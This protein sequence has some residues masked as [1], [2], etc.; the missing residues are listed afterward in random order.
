VA[1]QAPDWHQDPVARR[2]GRVEEESAQRKEQI[3]TNFKGKFFFLPQ[4]HHL[5][6]HRAKN[7][8]IG[9]TA[10]LIHKG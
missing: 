9:N 7:K 8:E 1:D 2:P 4:Q 5:H 10:T 3:C 6:I